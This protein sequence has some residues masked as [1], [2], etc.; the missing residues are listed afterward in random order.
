MTPAD[1]AM[2][3]LGV[4]PESHG[5]DFRQ[6]A[7]VINAAMGP[8]FVTVSS[9]KEY[10]QSPLDKELYLLIVPFQSRLGY[11]WAARLS[12]EATEVVAKKVLE[13]GKLI[14]TRDRKWASGSAKIKRFGGLN[15]PVAGTPMAAELRA[16]YEGG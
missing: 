6:G 10:V 15:I 3:K 14:R 5:S 9:D 4:R 12:S 8:D 1:I 13:G 2:L 7:A 16:L 11:A